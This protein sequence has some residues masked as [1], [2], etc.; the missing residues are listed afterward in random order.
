M[1]FTRLTSVTHILPTANSV[2]VEYTH[3]TPGDSARKYLFQTFSHRRFDGCANNWG[4]ILH[5]QRRT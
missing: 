5:S 1:G 4:I 3:G 2:A